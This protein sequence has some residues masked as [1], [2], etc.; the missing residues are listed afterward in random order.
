MKIQLN[1]NNIDFNQIEGKTGTT[2]KRKILLI[3]LGVLIALAIIFYF[4]FGNTKPQINEYNGT[5]DL[6]FVK[7]IIEDNEYYMFE[8]GGQK[9]ILFK[10]SKEAYKPQKVEIK[11]AK[12]H[13]KSYTEDKKLSINVSVEADITKQ[14]EETTNDINI[15]NEDSIFLVQK[16]SNDCTGL[17]VNNIEY[18]KFEGGKVTDKETQKVGYIDSNSNMIIPTEYSNI[19]EMNDSYYNVQSNSKEQIDYTNYLK[20]YKN[21]VGYGIATKEGKILI[22]CQYSTIVNFDAYTFAVT[23]GDEINSKIGIVDLYGNVIQEFK[24]GG[25]FD[26]SAEFEKYAIVTLNNKKGVMDRN[27][28]VIV[29]IQYDKITMRNFEEDSGNGTKYLFATENNGQ[30]EVFDENGESAVNESLNT[31]SQLFGKDINSIEMQEIYKNIL[32]SKMN[33]QNE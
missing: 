2:K 4:A 18:I 29:P 23:R 28:N 32:N 26:D 31:I 25:I 27:L 19:E 12:I 20:I 6:E 8:D 10:M 11:S 22:E 5:K 7:Q 33:S 1:G 15:F 9:Y 3:I 14:D 13:T 30:Y 24:D 21:G 16:I 17:V